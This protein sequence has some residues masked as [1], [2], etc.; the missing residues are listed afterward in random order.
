M[1][2]QYDVVVIGAGPAGL[3]ASLVLGRACRN[4]LLV[5]GGS[6]RNAVA[7]VAHGFLTRDG[8]SPRDLRRVARSQLRPYDVT[9]LDERAVNVSRADGGFRVW[10]EGGTEVSS[11]KVIF[12]TGLRDILPKFHGFGEIYGHSAHHCPYCDGWEWRGRAVAVYAPDGGPEYAMSLLPWTRDIVLCTDG[13]RVHSARD[14]RRLSGA[15]VRVVDAPIV[16]LKSRGGQLTSIEF[17][18]A[19]SLQRD[20]LFFYVGAEQASP[21]PSRIGC[22]VDRDGLVRVDE[23]CRTTQPGVYAAGDLTPGPQSAIMAA[24]DGA[25]A[26]AVAHQDLRVEDFG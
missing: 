7:S 15:G 2:R 21:L 11:R 25:K 1:H 14:V 5:D 17:D 4:V 24:A 12:A 6:P 26:G 22:A 19:R 13:G 20:V 16:D 10:L 3:S 23:A 9:D 8:T 18:G